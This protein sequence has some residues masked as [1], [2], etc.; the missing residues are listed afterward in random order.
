[1]NKHWPGY[2]EIQYVARFWENV[3]NHTSGKIK[4]TS[5][6]DSYTTVQTLK[7]LKLL[8]YSRL[9]SFLGGVADWNGSIWGLTSRESMANVWMASYSLLTFSVQFWK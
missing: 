4:L 2:I 5:P 6:V 8:N 7:L 9:A 3:P 1:M